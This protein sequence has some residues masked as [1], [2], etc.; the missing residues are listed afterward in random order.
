MIENYNP[1]K[2][3]F[4][5]IIYQDDAILVFNKP[6][7]LLSVPGRDPKHSDSL[8]IRAVEKFEDALIVHRLD[9][10]TSG[11]IIM[12][13]GKQAHRQLSMDFQDRKVEKT[14]IA[15]AF[16][17]M[18]EDEGLIDLPLICDWPNRPKQIVDFEVGKPSQTKWQVLKRGAQETLLKLMPITGRSHQLRVHL[19]NIEHPILG[20]RF[21]AHEKA[22]KM[23]ERLCLHAKSL[24]IT[25]PVT[26]KKMT[27]ECEENF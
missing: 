2:N 13:R 9:M 6:A 25:H 16:G 12:A 14:Y 26:L 5:D 17:V 3:P 11:L 18:A 7:G 27:F 8:Q 19:Q 10:D 21:Y 15:R 24:T 4:L 22:L 1:P 23:S 20:D